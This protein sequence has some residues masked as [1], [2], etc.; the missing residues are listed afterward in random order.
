MEKSKYWDPKGD[1]NTNHIDNH[2]QYKTGMFLKF[3]EDLTGLKYKLKI[4]YE[5]IIL[6][7]I[8]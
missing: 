4:I 2:F 6:F 7:Q 5:M 3:F 8:F 1:V